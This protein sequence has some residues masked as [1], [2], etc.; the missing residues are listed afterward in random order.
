MASTTSS[1]TIVTLPPA[2]STSTGRH[3]RSNSSRPAPA[4]ITASTSPVIR[5]STD[6]LPSTTTHRSSTGFLLPCKHTR[7]PSTESRVD[8]RTTSSRP[9]RKTRQP[10]PRPAAIVM[11]S[12]GI[13][14]TA[15][16]PSSARSTEYV[17]RPATKS[18]VPLIG[19]TSQRRPDVPDRSGRSSPAT[20]SSG[21][22]SASL[23]RTRSSIARSTEVTSLPSSLYRTCRVSE[24]NA[25]KAMSEASRT[26]RNASSRSVDM[27]ES[28]SAPATGA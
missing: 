18:A 17:G 9:L 26:M 27:V 6:M 10:T 8:T 12:D 16:A 28:L 11:S 25:D 19:S 2:S 14:E 1:S 23:L 24:L 15:S 13:A 3:A 20:A 4:A 22:A 7:A 5:L 21:T